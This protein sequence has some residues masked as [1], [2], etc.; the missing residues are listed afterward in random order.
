MNGG[1]WGNGRMG[2]GLVLLAG[3][4]AL[5]VFMDI[6]GQARPP[7]FCCDK[8]TCFQVAGVAGCSMVVAALENSVV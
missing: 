4:T 6:G 1:E 7:E 3:C 2:I 5:D 8:L